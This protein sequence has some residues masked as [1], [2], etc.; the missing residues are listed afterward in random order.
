MSSDIQKVAH[1]AKFEAI[2]TR[3]RSGYNDTVGEWPKN[4]VWDTM[5]A[6]H[7]MD[8]K[9]KVNLK[10]KLY[11]LL[12]M[13]GYDSSIDV[14]LEASKKE[15]DEFGSNA[16]NKIDQA[17]LDELLKYNAMDS[18]GTYKLWQH[19]SRRV[20]PDLKRGIELFTRGSIALVKAEQNGIMC[21]LEEMNKTYK[22]ITKKMSFYESEVKN[23]KEIS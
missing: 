20:G 7:V 2:W 5:L 17:P 9:K 15:G 19:Q 3:E 6:S 23:S 21:N 10:F 8:N 12:G 16:F 4:I 11:I 1:N 18:L 14:Y 22:S 13:A